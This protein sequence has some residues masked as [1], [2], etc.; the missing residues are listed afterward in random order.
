M[1]KKYQ[2][3]ARVK[4]AQ[5]QALRRDFE[6]LAMKDGESITNYFA[7]TMEICNRMRFHG[8]K[9][10]DVTIVEKI[11]RSLTAKFDYVVCAIEESKDID[12]LSLDELQ[13]SIVDEVEVEAEAG[14]IAKAEA[15]QVWRI[16]TASTRKRK[17]KMEPNRTN[18]SK[19]YGEKSNFA[20]QQEK[21]HK[22]FSVRMNDDV[23][24]W[25]FRY[26]HLNFGGLRTLQQK[27]MVIGLPKITPPIEVCEECMISKQHRNKFPKGKSWRAKGILDLEKSEAFLAFKSFKA[28]VENE[29]ERSIKVLR[30]DHGGEYCSKEFETYCDNHG[31]RREL[32]TAYTPQQ[33]GVAERKNRTIFN[34]VRSLLARGRVP[35]TFWPE[36]VN[37]SIHVLNRSPTFS[38]QDMTPEEAWNGRK[39]VVNYFKIF[40]CIAYAHIPDE[41]RKKL[42]E[43]AEKCVFL[44]VFV[45]QPPGYIKTGNEHKVYR[46]KKALYGLKQAPRAWYSRIEAYFLKVGFSKCPYEHT[47]F[48]KIGKGG[49]M[50][51][52]CLYVDDLIFTGNCDAMFQEFKK[53]MMDEFEM[54]DLGTMHY[55]LGIEVVNTSDGI[56]ISQ[57]KYIGE[58]L[59]RF[60]MKDCNAVS[61]PTEFGL[62][63]NKDYEGKKVDSTLYK[64]IVGSL[65]YLT[66]TRPDIMYSVSLIS[67]YMENPTEMHLGAKRILRYL[68]GTRDYGLFYR[69]G[70]KPTL[71]GFTDSDYAGDQDDRRSTS[72]YVFMLG[73]GAISWSSK[74]QRIVTLSS[75]E[76]EFLL[77]QRVRVKLFGLGEFWKS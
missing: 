26:G 14:E 23:W 71:L 25:H 1:K 62:K 17:R 56:F 51:I 19:E 18:L 43:K 75:T 7:R 57:K 9:M 21:S 12:A 35:K 32:T 15:E 44:G 30:T 27:N 4:R 28:R 52:V 46:L 58:I 38:V 74:K 53:C 40:G 54:S 37:W 63:L 33:N 42:D 13:S 5:L 36:A 29:S 69:K 60:L 11:L 47:L 10:Q 39:P 16:S 2:G 59:D 6:T 41:K 76:A 55:F 50:L 24:L 20:E 8:E 72:G 67:R 73:T 45:E 68:Q 49:K 64:Q 61:T 65:M 22:C 3:S 48:V 77:Q 66:A 31:I 34:M 70:E